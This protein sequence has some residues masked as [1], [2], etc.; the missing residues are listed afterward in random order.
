MIGTTAS[1]WGQASFDGLRQFGISAPADLQF[2]KDPRI[3]K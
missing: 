2:Q 1:H 3:L